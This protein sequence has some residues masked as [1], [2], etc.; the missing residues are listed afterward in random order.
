[1]VGKN[2]HEPYCGCLTQVC[3]TY[4]VFLIN[5]TSFAYIYAFETK[6]MEVLICSPALFRQYLT[7]RFQTSE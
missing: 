4:A 5:K 3:S 6:K 2:I 7:R 1:M